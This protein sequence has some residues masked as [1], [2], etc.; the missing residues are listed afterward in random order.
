MSIMVREYKLQLLIAFFVYLI[1]AAIF[2]LAYKYAV[3]PD[4]V[5]QLRLAGYIA[6]GHF[7]RS[8]TQNWSPLFIWLMSPFLFFG[9]DGLITARITIALSGALL[10]FF[11][12]LFIQRFELSKNQSFIVLLIS[13]LLISDWTIRNIGA[14]LPFTALLILYMYFL[15]HPNIINNK[16]ISFFC[17][18]SGGFSYLAHHYAF[19]FFIIHYPISML[20][21]KYF[22]RSSSRVFSRPLMLGFAGFFIIC[23]IWIGIMSIKY[24]RL[25][26]SA[27]GGI[28]YAAFGPKSSGGHP[29]FKGGLYKPRD[30]YAIHLFEDISDVKYNTWSPFESREHFLHQMHLIKMNINYIVSHFVKSSPFFTYPFVIGILAIIPIVLLLTSLNREKKFLYLWVTMTFLVYSSGFILIIARSPRRFYVLMLMM[31]I[32]SFSIF[33][34]LIKLFNEKFIQK[35]WDIWK[36]GILMIYLL[37]IIIPAFSLKPAIHLLKSFKNVATLE[38]VNPYQDIV[39]QL[40]QVDF[41]APVAFIRSSQKGYTDLYLAYFMNKQLL[42]RPLSEDIE[43]ITDEL[44]S[45]GG[46]SLL[47]FDNLDIVDKLKGD[48]RYVYLTTIRLRNDER[49]WNFPNIKH[50]EI[51]A[52]DREVSIFV[53]KDNL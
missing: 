45:A 43:G 53:L 5:A 16:R 26:I 23:S 25:T 24:G 2:G 9:L 19:P 13:A 7:M 14:D 34:E 33:E 11:S 50:D 49:Y 35:E 36:K 15:T 6:E 41:P 32:S 47:V 29:F 46:K 20:L 51:T 1:C 37:F 42:G 18:V 28:T 52:W 12:W 17:G 31:I 22:S 8:V 27:K 30:S 38:Y 4:G 3:N 39:E 48:N 40:K 44:K 10:L 21:R